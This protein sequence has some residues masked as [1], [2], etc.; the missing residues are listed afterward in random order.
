MKE[1]DFKNIDFLKTGNPLQVAAWECLYSLNLFEILKE[2]DPILAGTIPIGLN[3][4][5]SD[6]DVLCCFKEA[7]FFR[8][9]VEE[10]FFDKKDF[11][12]KEKIL[13]EKRSIIASFYEQGFKIE[14]F[15]QKTPTVEQ[16]AWKHMIK[17]WELLNK[18]GSELKSMV[19]DL[20]HKGFSTEH[21]FAIALDLHGDPYEAI[22][23]AH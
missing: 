14:L 5:G 19:I 8:S 23:F 9:V 4:E 11:T 17:E 1:E 15:G 12:L 10:L 13:K 21:A 3:I 16:M 20:K 6:L 7:I 2:F 18:Y 22:L